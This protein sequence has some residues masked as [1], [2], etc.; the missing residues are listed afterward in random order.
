MTAHTAS[1]FP[2]YRPDLERDACGIGLVAD[3]HGHRSHHLVEQALT[4]LARLE[5]RGAPAETA[6]VDG[7]GILTQIPWELLIEDLPPAFTREDA[8]RMA[9]VLFLPHRHAHELMPLVERTLADAGW[10]SLTWRTV[11]VCFDG[12]DRVRDREVPAIVQIAGIAGAQVVNADASLYHAQLRIEDLGTRFRAD[13]FAVVSLSTRTVVYK[14]LLTPGELP[15]FF[16]D[17]RHAAFRS[18]IA[19]V[20]QRFSTNTFAQWSLAQPFHLLAHNGEISTIAGNRRWMKARLLEAG[21]SSLPAGLDEG[22]SDS[23]SLDAAA[24]AL[25]QAGYALPHVMSRL[26]PPAW[27]NDVRMPEHVRAFYEYQ[28]RF[29]EPW[30]GPAAI[31][32]SDGRL[33]GALLDRNGFRPARYIR[34]IDGRL[35]L[36]SEAGIFDI[37]DAAIVERGRLGPG[38]MIVVDTERGHVYETDAIREQLA[39]QRPYRALVRDST[40][41]WPAVTAAPSVMQSDHGTLARFHRLFGYSQ[42]ELDLILRPMARDGAE[43]VGSMGDDTPPAVLSAFNRVLPDYFRQRF[44]QVTNPPMDPIRE[45]CVMSLR[46]LVGPAAQGCDEDAPQPRA[47]PLHSPILDASA[48][49]RII[50]SPLLAPVALPLRFAAN[51]GPGALRKALD[52]LV[53][54]A[55]EGIRYGARVLVLS[56]RCTGPSFAPIPPLLA[57]AAVHQ[58]LLAHGI[59]MRASLIVETGEVRD[60]HQLA[61]LFAYGASAVFPYLAF[62]T[63][64]SLGEPE[65]SL[66][67]VDRYRA[68]LDHGL[69]KV[70][71]KMGVTTFTGY[72][73]S[74]LF[75]VL[76]LDRRMVRLYFPGAGSPL[77]GFRLA[78]LERQVLDRHASAWTGGAATLAYPGFHS[79]RRGGEQHAYNPAVVKQ[80]HRSAGSNSAD[81]YRAFDA[82]VNERPVTALRDLVQWRPSTPIPEDEVES[83]DVICKR[84][85]SAA[86]SIGALSPEAHEALATAM[87]RLGGRSNS[88]EGGE[89]PNRLARRSGETWSGSAIK[90]VASAR[91][92]VTPAYLR[93]ADELQIK[94]A[95]GSKPG[96]GGQLPAAKVVE[97]IAVLRY[98]RPGTPLISPPVHHDIYSIEDLA[99]LIFDLRRFHPRARINVKLVAAAGVGIVAA[100][101]AKAG[102]D[103]ILISGHDGG[104]GASPRA[105]IKHAGL[106]WELGLAEAHQVLTHHGLRHGVALQVDGGLQRGRDVAIAAALGADEYGFGTAALVAIGCVMARQCHLDTCPVGIATQRADLRGKFAGTPD[107]LIAYLRLVAADVRRIVAGLGLRSVAALVGRADLL[108][109]KAPVGAESLLDLAPL[110]AAAPVLRS[111]PAPAPTWMRP[112][113]PDEFVIPE[114]PGPSRP[115]ILVRT[116]RNTDRAIATQLAGQ[117]TERF[118]AAGL[119]PDSVTMRLDGTAG[120]S[121]G[122]FL[123]P[124]LNVQLRGEANDYVGKG[125]H[126]GTISIH[127]PGGKAGTAGRPQVLAGN[128]VLYGATGGRLFIGGMAGERFA[129][130]NSGASAVVEGVGDHGCEYMTAGLVVVLGPIGRNF[131]SGM[132]GGLAFVLARDEPA[133]LCNTASVDVIAATS[134]D[135]ELLEPLLVE[136]R[137]L[138]GS[139]QADVL[140]RRGQRA[141]A[142]LRKVLPNTVRPLTSTVRQSPARSISARC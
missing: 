77:G 34:T 57:T 101:A 65:E 84:F 124:G 118:G 116:V 85:F 48:F 87:N 64:A 5:H 60:P 125:M 75:D 128:A 68:A 28:A 14:G 27:E 12:L 138:T 109:P 110:L 127:P 142:G 4:A 69:L 108:Q 130:R 25:Q 92:G 99:Q 36:G 59:R 72:C 53:A 129:V 11:P 52:D 51:G 66:L 103:A 95:Q 97:H 56:D 131:G 133:D 90:Q 140:L 39:R 83:A 88:G 17:L 81:A 121:L 8:R 113:V 13:G 114:D 54:A 91:F 132:S 6:S 107:M 123:V 55:T 122:A 46:V 86:M 119:P 139:E 26:V 30:D 40:V 9:G 50:A 78:D 105:S 31:A 112:G 79:Y 33:A 76:G 135:W 29:S 71:S 37:P 98:A 73:G 89:S 16:V 35:Y 43:A 63:V 41:P 1:A 104:T 141:V 96:E 20:H 23:C 3:I 18:A 94:I 134:E 120:Q 7:S 61:T 74:G 137:R 19:I 10:T 38:Q 22:V 80:L 70:C 58:G 44:A 106:P 117:I 45:A 93:S 126:G 100:G 67:R 21:S 49:E 62:A 15:A 2:L 82:L 24:Q 102:A 136:H 115:T 111:R 32:F 47:L 42:E